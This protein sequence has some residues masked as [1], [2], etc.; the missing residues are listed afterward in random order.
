[1]PGGYR[2]SEGSEKGTPSWPRAFC[3]LGTQGKPPEGGGALVEKE[4]DLGRGRRGGGQGGRWD[5]SAHAK[6][7]CRLPLPCSCFLASEEIPTM[8]TGLCPVCSATSEV[9][10]GPHSLP[11]P[12]ERC[13]DHQPS[14]QDRVTLGWV[15][16]LENSSVLCE[17]G[18]VN[19]AGQE[20]SQPKQPLNSF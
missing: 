6:G 2:C 17:E 7:L 3:S 19:T 1:M 16:F 9:P 10:L 4:Q 13:P 12:P 18:Y 8:L 5:F 15:R 11:N 20:G 14:L